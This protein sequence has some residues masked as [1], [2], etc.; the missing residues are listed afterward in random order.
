[1]F[2]APEFSCKLQRASLVALSA[3][4]GSSPGSWS[5]F[6]ANRK[7]TAPWPWPPRSVGRC[8]SP[9]SSPCQCRPSCTSLPE[10]ETTLKTWVG[11]VAQ[12]LCLSINRSIKQAKDRK[13]C[14]LFSALFLHALLSALLML[15]HYLVTNYVVLAVSLVASPV[16]TA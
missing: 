8:Q 15:L 9:E 2:K 5:T 11:T 13:S 16:T 3:L 10:N 14:G 4:S 1:M 12:Q 7:R 6:R